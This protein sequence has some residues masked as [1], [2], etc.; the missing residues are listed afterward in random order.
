MAGAALDDLTAIVDYIAQDNP[1][2]AERFSERLLGKLGLLAHSPQLGSVCPYHRK[3][4]QL[5]Y[6]KYIVYYTVHRTDVVI[7][8]VVHGARHFRSYW[9]RRGE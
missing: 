7:R 6:G 2:A 9:L 5:V 8:A 3:T 4:R 1:K